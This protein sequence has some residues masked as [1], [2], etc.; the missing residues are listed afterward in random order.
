L[1]TLKADHI[2]IPVFKIGE[3][4]TPDLWVGVKFATKPEFYKKALEISINRCEGTIGLTITE[5]TQ[6]VQAFR[7]LNAAEV[8]RLVRIAQK[9]KPIQFDKNDTCR[10]YKEK[11]GLYNGEKK[12]KLPHPE[13]KEKT[14]MTR[15]E[16]H[17]AIIK[18]FLKGKEK[19]S[20]TEKTIVFLATGG[21]PGAGKGTALKNAIKEMIGILPQEPNPEKHYV[22][23][24]PDAVK[25]YLP[26]YYN[27]DET[28]NGNRVHRES[29]DIADMI[30]QRAL[31]KGYSILY[32]SSM[33]DS[34]DF[35]WYNYIVDEARNS[36]HEPKVAFVYD[37][38]EAWYRNSVIRD[39]ALPAANYLDFMQ[40]YRT[41][42]HLALDEKIEATMY[43]NSD[44]VLTEKTTEKIVTY[45][46]GEEFYRGKSIEKLQKFNRFIQ[47]LNN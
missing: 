33:R 45:K 39:R 8:V 12:Y 2:G 40:S 35:R 20:E 36:G 7:E 18:K 14:E 46:N 17:E 38:G 26:E 43:N 23:V 24:D 30:R 4:I 41:F 1:T 11:N 27:E 22:V 34:P 44:M 25:P 10:T 31:K 47:A 19:P 6:L 28:V 29:G 32:D 9:R 13:T 3:I 21:L 37:G 5:N 42:Y 16:L 15:V